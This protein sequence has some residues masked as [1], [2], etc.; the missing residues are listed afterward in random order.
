M[1]ASL[2]P[3]MPCVSFPHIT[4]ELAQLN[5]VAAQLGFSRGC[6]LQDPDADRWDELL[7]SSRACSRCSRGGRVA[8]GA[9]DYDEDDDDDNDDD[10]DDDSRRCI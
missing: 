1:R 8:W 2:W 3:V 6:D 7:G 9:F 5:N 10:E 4:C